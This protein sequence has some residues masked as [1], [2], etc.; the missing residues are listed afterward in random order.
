LPSAGSSES[1]HKVPKDIYKAPNEVEFL[2]QILFVSCCFAGGLALDI[3]TSWSHESQIIPAGRREPP[4]YTT[5]MFCTHNYEENGL[6]NCIGGVHL[7][8]SGRPSHRA[9]GRRDLGCGPILSDKSRN[10]AGPFGWGCCKGGTRNGSGE[11]KRRRRHRENQSFERGAASGSS[12]SS[13]KKIGFGE[14]GSE[15]NGYVYSQ[16]N[17]AILGTEWSAKRST[18]SVQ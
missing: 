9:P 6:L 1:H 16:P 2:H 13:R 5:G 12:A 14:S 8:S 4:R 10:F 3:R 11:S 15:I 17:F 18:S 7:G